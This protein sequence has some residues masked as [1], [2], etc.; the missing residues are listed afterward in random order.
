MSHL[1]ISNSTIWSI[2]YLSY[3]QAQP[4]SIWKIVQNSRSFI[5]ILNRPARQSNSFRPEID[6]IS[7]RQSLWRANFKIHADYLEKRSRTAWGCTITGGPWCRPLSVTDLWPKTEL[8]EKLQFNCVDIDYYLTIRGVSQ[9]TRRAHHPHFQKFSRRKVDS[10]LNHHWMQLLRRSID[11]P[12]RSTP[13]IPM[14]STLVSKKWVASI[15]NQ[16][17]ITRRCAGHPG[18]LKRTD[19]RQIAGGALLVLGQFHFLRLVLRDSHY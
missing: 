9:N 5:W 10:R 18:P 13:S 15:Q 12:V 1:I 8:E 19:A 2:Q 3:I 14:S 7:S 4:C 17:V 11:C 16:I 6:I